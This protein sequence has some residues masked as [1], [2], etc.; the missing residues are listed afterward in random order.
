MID[1]I[2]GSSKDGPAKRATTRRSSRR[3]P[4]TKSLGEKCE[5][6]VRTS[7]HAF[8]SLSERVLSSALLSYHLIS[9]GESK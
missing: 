9:T 5:A 6:C 7:T 1:T 2:L 3:N 4:A 8:P